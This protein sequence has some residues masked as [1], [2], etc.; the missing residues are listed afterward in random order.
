MVAKIVRIFA[1]VIVSII[2]LNILLFIAFSIPAVQKS[3]ANMA[4]EKF[5]PLLKTKIDL[6]SIRIRLFNTVEL[7]GVYVED[8][9]QDTLLY[10]GKIAVRLH[11]LDLL[12]NKVTVHKV[13]LE[14][15]TANIHRTSPDDPFNFQFIIDAFAKE[16]TLK[17]EK[18]KKPW[19]I[20]ANEAILKNGKLRY[21]ILSVPETPGTFN[22]SHIDL[23]DFNF[24]GKADFLSLEDMQAEVNHL[25]FLEKNAGLSLHNLKARVRG[26]DSLLSTDGVTVALNGSRIQIKDAA[27]DL[28]SKA[29]SL[30][31]ESNMIDPRDVTIFSSRVAHLDKP[32]SFEI[33]AEGEL[34]QAVL[35][36]LDF[37]YGS[38]TELNI[39][40]SVSD[41]SD[42]NNGELHVNLRNLS[43]S[44]ED[45]EALF[46]AGSPDFTPPDQ[47][48]A[49]GDLDLRIKADGHLKQFLYDGDLTTEQGQVTL[50]GT[51]RIGNE[52]KSFVFEGPVRARNIQVA[53]IIG[54][55]AGVGTTTLTTDVKIS[56]LQDAGMTVAADGRIESTSFRDYRY[57]NIFFDGVYSGSSVVA[58]IRSDMEKNK[59]DLSG[60][61][62]FG[63]AMKFDVKADVERLDL[64]PFVANESWKDPYLRVNIDGN[65]AGSSLD[66]LT[67]TVVMENISLGDSNFIYNPGAIFLEASADEGQGKK[68]EFM[69]SF[70]EGNITGDYY[71]ST[72]GAE[73]MQVIHPHLPSVIGVKEIQQAQPE[74]GKNNFQ[75]NIQLQNTEDLSYALSLPFYNVEPATISGS[76]DMT[77]EESLRIDAHLP[78]LMVGA[79]DIRETKVNLLSGMSGLGLDVNSYLVQN[80]G[81]MNVKLH[82]DAVSDSVNNHLSFDIQQNATR[83]NG[84]LLIAAGFLRDSENRLAA[85]IHLLPASIIFNGKQIDF[86]DA[87]IAY[88]TD[89]IVIS[90]FGMREDNMLLLGIEGVAS[91]NETDNIRIYFNNTELANILNTFNVTNFTGSING[92]IYVQQALGD[93]MIRTEDLRIENITAQGDTIGT[94]RVEAN[95]DNV[96]SGLNLNAWLEDRGER[97]LDIQGYIPTG[98]NSTSPMD[99]NLKITDF[100]L[101]AIKPFTTDIFSELDGRLN[102]QIRVTGTLSAPITEGWLGIDDGM[103]KVAFTNVTYYI[104][105]KIEISRDNVGLKDL[106]IR[107]QNNHTATL[108]VSLSHT[109]FGRM[110]YKAGIRFNDF[111]LLNN[112]NRTDLMAYGSLKLS[113]ELNVTGS[114]SGIFGDGNL[115]SSSKSNVTIVVPQTAKATEYSGIIYVSSKFREPDSLTFLRKNEETAGQPGRNMSQGIPIVMNITVNLNQLLE[116]GVVLDPTTGNALNVS[117][118][119]ELNINFNSRATPSARLYGDYV[120][121]DGKFH[122]N[123]QNLRSIDFNIREGSKLSMEGNPMNTQFNVTAYLPVKADLTAL[124]PTF[125][126][127]LANTRVAVNALLHIRGD[128]EEM[129]LQYD[130][131]LPESSNDI[132]QRV[133]SFIPDEETKILQFAYLVTTGNFIPSQGSPDLDFG[134]SV[135]T[136]LA[137]NTLSRGLDAL[138]ARALSDNWSISTNL[139]SVDGTLDNVRMGVDVSTRLMNNRLRINTNLSYGDNS[140]LAGQQAFLGEFELEYDINNWLMLRA[141]NR[142]NERF[143]RRAPTTQGV[144]V[145]VTREAKRFRDLFDFRFIRK[146]EEKE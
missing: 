89:S 83:S 129:D 121:H 127:E 120:I 29:F 91:K 32:I 23:Q 104:S 61:M 54:K 100:K 86:N 108:N 6:E 44:Q 137:A 9:Q 3:V 103:M 34:P 75:F 98:D 85:N 79:N 41:Y 16:D 125:S 52:F 51:G 105:D 49:M 88:S 15:F 119:G 94:F 70:F 21:N 40:G 67:G 138:F 10:V 17:V 42:I 37:R 20:T 58:E 47:L 18:E 143:Y 80:T 112:A 8:L 24:R 84:E 139:E 135:F 114:P 45:L 74:A 145:M 134:S 99:I 71:F 76:V 69:S 132:Q 146:K 5:R 136:K 95:W 106:V 142:A 27:Y 133:N 107:D 11:A 66:D 126:T 81:Y 63:E 68:I 38:D 102:S 22:V 93:P 72:I 110:V 124:S 122:Y 101:T 131:E 109:N 62:T 13:G 50:K 111:M 78:R 46:R 118:D 35:N 31:A 60:N 55:D 65:L 140:M 141:F 64:T 116:A 1:I 39:S 25:N 48:Q 73:L 87:T 43:V 59:F 117:G 97:S 113:G 96:L 19:R 12:R 53:N 144:G 115:T 26:E 56:V 90:N 123:I 4:L 33:S 14:N 82:S 30:T 7:E 128:L 28:G 36:N 57:N 77:T 130:I 92:E 2:L